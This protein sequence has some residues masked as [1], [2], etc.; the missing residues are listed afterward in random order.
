MEEDKPFVP[1]REAENKEEAF[2]S[3]EDIALYSSEEDVPYDEDDN[4]YEID[5]EAEDR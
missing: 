3:E 2:N 5:E 4:G 1:P